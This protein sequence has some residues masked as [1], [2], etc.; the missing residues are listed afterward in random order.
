MAALFP[1]KL[2]TCSMGTPFC[3]IHEAAVCRSVWGVTPSSPARRAAA[4][5]PV[6]MLATL[7]SV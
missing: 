2:A 1:R 6:L 5:K 7:F 3:T 4:L